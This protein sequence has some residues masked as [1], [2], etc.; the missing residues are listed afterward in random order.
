[1]KMPELGGS[2]PAFAASSSWGCPS[3]C[4]LGVARTLAAFCLPDFFCVSSSTSSCSS[5]RRLYHCLDRRPVAFHQLCIV[6][7]LE[8]LML[9]VIGDC[10]FLVFGV[11]LQPCACRIL[12]CV[13]QS[14][15]LFCS[16]SVLPW[17]L[18]ALFALPW[19][20][21]RFWHVRCFVRC[22]FSPA[23]QVGRL[24]RM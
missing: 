9:L 3:S 6:L 5:R 21:F 23:L 2:R 19:L 13:L 4:R 11:E 14:H 17:R 1:L 18:C 16:R 20:T 15:L 10:S 22:P 8:S 24:F 7:L 12:K